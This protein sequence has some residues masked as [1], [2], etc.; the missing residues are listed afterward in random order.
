[1]H[2]NHAAVLCHTPRSSAAHSISTLR[3]MTRSGRM[4]VRDSHQFGGAVQAALIG[5]PQR[6]STRLDEPPARIDADCEHMQ[7]NC[8]YLL[9]E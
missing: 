1:V 9:P 2:T 7:L 6:S 8:C 4:C 3:P 5:L